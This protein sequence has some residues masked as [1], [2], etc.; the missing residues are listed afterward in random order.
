[1][2]RMPFGKHRGAPIADLPDDYLEWLVG[3]G[4]LREPLRREVE[5]EYRWR[6][7]VDRIAPSSV[8]D[9]ATEIV[10]AGYRVMATRCHPDHGGATT[11]M[12]AVNAAA[13]WLR[14]QLRSLTA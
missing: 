1:M 10:S 6:T 5:R 8:R 2:T 4:D 11:A 9:A 12:Q 7:G 13:T 14:G 3:L